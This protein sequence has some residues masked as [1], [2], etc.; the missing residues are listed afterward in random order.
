MVFELLGFLL[1]I[2]Y[3]LA[4]PPSGQIKVSNQFFKKS[5]FLYKNFFIFFKFNKLTLKSVEVNFVSKCFTF[6]L[7][8]YNKLFLKKLKNQK[9]IEISSK[10]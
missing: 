8:K 3:M 5:I 6:F 9:K 7:V 1:S 2:Y 4:T 10:N